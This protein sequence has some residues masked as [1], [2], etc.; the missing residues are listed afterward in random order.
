MPDPWWYLK[1]RR[2]PGGVLGRPKSN[3]PL[4]ERRKLARQKYLHTAHLVGTAAVGG[5]SGGDMRGALAR[6]GGP[7][8]PGGIRYHGPSGD[9]E[10]DRA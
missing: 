10:M 6:P 8:L 2:N 5:V 7:A 9:A 4:H 1:R 3:I